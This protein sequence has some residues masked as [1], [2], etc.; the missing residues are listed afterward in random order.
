MA[1]EGGRQGLRH[2][3]ARLRHRRPP[4]TASARAT[5]TATAAST[6]S[7]PRAGSRPPS[8]PSRDTWTWHPDWNLGATGIQILAKDVDGDGLADLVY[9]MGH[10][11][12]LFWMKQGKS[13]RGER[14]WTK[15]TIDDSVASVH[16]LLWADL[17]GDGKANE[18]DHRQARLCPRDRAGRDRRLA[19]RLVSASTRRQK[20][21]AKHVIFQGEPAKNA[22]AKAADRLAL[23][24]FPAGTAGTGLQMTAIDLDG[25]GDLDLLC[26]GKSG[27]YVFENLCEGRSEA[28]ETGTRPA[29]ETPCRDL[30]VS[31]NSPG[32]APAPSTSPGA[33]SA[34][35]RFAASSRWS[36][37]CSWI[38]ASRSWRQYVAVAWPVP[39]RSGTASCGFAIAP[40]RPTCRAAGPVR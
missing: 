20:A 3:E 30:R 16:A 29:P 28:T 11:Y 5:S 8:N 21:W 17:D 25:D 33:S 38:S 34:R 14:T 10:D 35:S 31:L 24:D 32:R 7:R 13:A 23:R 2:Q 1:P 27:L 12:G 19:R 39:R 4:A 6:C 26:P 15:G 40:G 36:V 18:L 9:G 37:S 22:P